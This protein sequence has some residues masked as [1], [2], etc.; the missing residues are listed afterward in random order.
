MTT[1]TNTQTYVDVMSNM[2][3]SAEIQ[4]KMTEGEMV[5]TIARMVRTMERITENNAANQDNEFNMQQ[6]AD[7][8]TAWMA[9]NT[10][11]KNHR[12]MIAA[13]EYAETE[14]NK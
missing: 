11:N 14:S 1:I 8:V 7:L 2:K 3:R 9:A 13:I 6:M 10:A 12:H 5:S 4:E